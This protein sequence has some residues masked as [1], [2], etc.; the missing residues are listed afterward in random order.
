MKLLL[1][2]GSGF[3]GSHMS[4]NLLRQTTHHVWVY[5]LTA[6]KLAESLGHPRLTYI[7]GDIRTDHARLEELVQAADVVV[8]L[9]AYANPALYV[10]IPLEVYQLNFT[11][12]LTIA[13]YCVKHRKRLIQFSSCEVYGKSVVPLVHNQLADPDNPMYAVFQEDTSALILGPVNKHRWIYSCAKQLLERILHAYGLEDRLNYTIIRPFN[14]IGPRIDYLPGK[15]DGNPRVF[16]HFVQALKDG[17]PMRLVNGGYQRRAYTYIEDAVDCIARI[18]ENSDRVCDKQIFNIGTPG[19][20]ISIRDLALK[21]RKIYTC[22]WWDGK[23][24][25]PELVDV[26]GTDFYGAGYDD[27]DRRIPDITKASTLLGWKP[28]YNL[29]MTLEH[30]MRYWF[31]PEASYI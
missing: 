4:A 3:I 28:Q 13:E 24:R 18:I 15:R 5:D 27:T 12:N 10:A 21:M 26:S 1:L 25:L 16:S 31:E 2:G 8:D 30:S 9:I 7:Y 17:T 11:E 23:Q 19:N 29:E 14:F 20:E 6:D 22:R